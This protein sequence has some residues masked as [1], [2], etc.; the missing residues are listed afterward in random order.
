MKKETGN[1]FHLSTTSVIK[2]VLVVVLTLALFLVRDVILIL[3][4]ALVIASAIEPG[5][6]KLT[7]FKIPRVISVLMI[8]LSAGV[9]FLVV[10]L[11][12]VPPML[13]EISKLSD[14]LPTYIE[15][16]KFD[17]VIPDTLTS[18]SLSGGGLVDTISLREAIVEM[19]EFL[20]S[21]SKG[22]FQTATIIFGGALS[23]V[24]VLVISFYLAVEEQGI[25]NFLRVIIPQEK[26]EYFISLWK[27]TQNKIGLWL[28]GQLLLGIVVGVLV[29][30]GLTILGVPYATSLA[31]LAAFLEIIPIFGPIIAAVPAILVGFS[32]SPTLGLTVLGLYAIIQQFENHLITPLV[33]TKIVGIP[34]IVVIVALLIGGKL[35]GFLGFLLAVPLTTI[36]VELFN[37]LEREKFATIPHPSPHE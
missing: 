33:I 36:L 12:F 31:A 35:A 26:E 10:T 6:C 20:A 1:I 7:K 8:Y 23:A 2:A 21:L 29:Y 28:Q 17:N 3:L 25:Q 27:R 9:I 32:V 16:Y 22:F 37:D 5:V 11:I 4:T 15:T 14:T 13:T 30:L 24:L 34:P 19:R 18:E